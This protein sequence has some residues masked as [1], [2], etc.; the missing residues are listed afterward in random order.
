[1]VIEIGA[2]APD[3]ELPGTGGEEIAQYRLSEFTDD[4]MVLLTF[5]PFDFSPVCTDQLCSLRD[6]EW[7]T[8]DESV[9][10]VGISVDSAY[11]HR[12]FIRE[13]DL[14]FPLLTDR[15]A[16][17]A[18]AYDLEYEEWEQHP[19][20]CQRALVAVDDDRE[21]RYTWQTDDA[22][23]QPTLDDLEDSIAWFRNGAG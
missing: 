21:V 7:L 17:V 20:V 2:T 15:L 8:V 13:H 3:F 9:D 6:A 23:N 16:D 12:R 14:M 11:S 10:V 1:M 22:L 19:S 18:A 4:G 5:Y